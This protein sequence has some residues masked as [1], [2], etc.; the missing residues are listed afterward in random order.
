MGARQTADCPRQEVKTV[1]IRISILVAT[2]ALLAG[3][4]GTGPGMTAA[5]ATIAPSTLAPSTPE[6]SPT[7]DRSKPVGLIAMG[8]SGITGEGTGEL[9]KA[10]PEN[11]WATG[12]LPEVNSVYL[13][14]VGIL[15]ETE[16]HV[17]NTGQGGAPASRLAAM[18]EGALSTVP[19]PA[20]AIIQTIDQD[21]K[22]DGKDADRMDSFGESVRKA[23]QIVVQASPNGHVLIVGQLGRPSAAFLEALVAK[24]P[25][26]R[27]AL[28]GVGPCD[29]FDPSGELNDEHIANLTAIIDAFEAE[30]AK[31]CAEFSQC[32]TDRGVRAAYTDKLENFSSDWNH[33]NVRGQAAEAELIWP[34][35]QKLLGQ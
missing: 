2:L 12:T 35:V 21:I 22:C 34:V 23:I 28:T 14:M 16:G 17:A 18:A 19:V 25:S 13:R 3:C 15:P 4:G 6:P 29:F 11:S 8:H 27:D 30:Q 5:P 9:G 33:L 24:A 7:P 20:L 10:V 31:V 32:T 1:R 26:Q